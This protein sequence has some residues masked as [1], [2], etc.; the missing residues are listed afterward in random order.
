MSVYEPYLC[1]YFPKLQNGHL[2]VIKS[3]KK[4]V[5]TVENRGKKKLQKFLPPG[6]VHSRKGARAFRAD[7]FLPA[8]PS[9]ERIEYD[10]RYP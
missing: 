8:E 4:D 6:Y 5:E 7:S 3:S 10:F 9:A 1:G 2:K